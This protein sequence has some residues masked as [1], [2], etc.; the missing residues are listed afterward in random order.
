MSLNKSAEFLANLVDGHPGA[1]SVIKRILQKGEAF[2]GH[3]QI[4]KDLEITGVRIW[5]GYK[6]YSEEKLD[7]FLKA[8]SK[9]DEKMIAVIEQALS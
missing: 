3:F 1:M 9:R 5:I 4:M 6:V 8:I 2:Y 7:V